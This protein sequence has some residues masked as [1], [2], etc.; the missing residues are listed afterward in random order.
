[1]HVT[2]HVPTRGQNME[3][4]LKNQAA[5]VSTPKQEKPTDGGASLGETYLVQRTEGEWHV[6]ELI[7]KRDNPENDE[8]EYYVHY[9]G[10]K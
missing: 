10:C 4:P 8:S 2:Y 9:D 5:N 7:Q 1:M 6:A 3:S